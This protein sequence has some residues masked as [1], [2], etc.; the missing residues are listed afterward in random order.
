MSHGWWEERACCGASAEYLRTRAQDE[1]GRIAAA[2]MLALDACLVTTTECE[3]CGV[4][5]LWS[6]AGDLAYTTTQFG[7]QDVPL[8]GER[9]ASPRRA[10]NSNNLALHL[11]DGPDI[12]G[13]R[14]TPR[15]PPARVL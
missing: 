7:L 13:R 3:R 2:L 11:P 14:R 6:W 10:H 5:S 12:L 1:E 8:R 4:P 9:L 15:R